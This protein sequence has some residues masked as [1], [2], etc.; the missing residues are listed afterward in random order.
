MQVKRSI[1]VMKRQMSPLTPSSVSPACSRIKCMWK[2]LCVCA[3]V[4]MCAHGCG[5]Q[6]ST[7][8]VVIPQGPQTLF[9]ETRSLTGLELTK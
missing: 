4:K 1:G 8:G 9:C 2:L 5:R 6:R 3:C 7:S